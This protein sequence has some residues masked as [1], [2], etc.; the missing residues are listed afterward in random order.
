[1]YIEIVKEADEIIGNA[2]K[3]GTEISQELKDRIKLGYIEFRVNN[4]KV[5]QKQIESDRIEPINGKA[6]VRL[7]AGTGCNL[8][9]RNEDLTVDFLISGE[10]VR[11][12]EWAF[13]D[14]KNGTFDIIEELIKPYI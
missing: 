8:L 1:M 14:N 7:Y 6:T 9:Q 5:K 4:Y 2:E 11:I 13:R 10:K 3:L 12:P